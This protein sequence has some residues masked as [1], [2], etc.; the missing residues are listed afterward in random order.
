MKNRILVGAI[1]GGLILA[2]ALVVAVQLNSGSEPFFQKAAHDHVK[3]MRFVEPNVLQYVTRDNEVKR[4]GAET[5][6][7]ETQ[8]QVKGFHVR[9]SPSGEYVSHAKDGK[10]HITTVSSERTNHRLHGSLHRWQDESS[11]M[12][13]KNQSKPSVFLEEGQLTRYH[14][15]TTNKDYVMDIAGTVIHPLNSY[16]GL[17]LTAAGQEVAENARLT[18]YSGRKEAE[19]AVSDQPIQSTASAHGLMAFQTRGDPTLKLINRHGRVKPTAIQPRESLYRPV[20]GDTIAAE[21]TSADQRKIELYDVS[22]SVVERQLP[23]GEVG[24]VI[25]VAATDS[26]VA[27]ATTNGIYVGAL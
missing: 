13:I 10:I 1:A 21:I 25:D 24:E 14:L 6:R 18:L 4:L 8:T 7:T 19:V 5:F 11:L 15:E 2:T 16:S 12:Y 3:H 9:L 22:Q 23:L 20:D 27:V 26:Y 17:I